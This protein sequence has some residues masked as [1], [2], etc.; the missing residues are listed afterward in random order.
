MQGEGRPGERGFP[1]L[2]GPPG[3]P[4][5]QVS[6]GPSVLAKM[7]HP[8]I[9]EELHNLLFCDCGYL[10]PLQG[11]TGPPGSNGKRGKVGRRGRRGPP[12]DAMV[13][14]LQKDDICNEDNT[15]LLRFNTTQSEQKLLFCDGQNWKVS[16]Q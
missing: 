1:G 6:L 2:Q 9:I 8:L 7:T 3:E 14:I 4:G 10:Q 16:I 11:E 12:G 15:G 13:G 5:S